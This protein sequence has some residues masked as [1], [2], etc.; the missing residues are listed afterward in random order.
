MM[1]PWLGLMSD[2]MIFNVFFFFFLAFPQVG[3]GEK[4]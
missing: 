2:S 4:G 3:E 1:D